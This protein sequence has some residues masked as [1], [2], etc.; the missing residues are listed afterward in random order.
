[1]G[2][3]EWLGER[4]QAAPAVSTVAAFAVPYGCSH[5]GPHGLGSLS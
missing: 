3:A 1:M 4:H 5:T 2:R